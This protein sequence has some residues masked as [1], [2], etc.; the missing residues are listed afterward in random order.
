MSSQSDAGRGLGRLLR[1]PATVTTRLCQAGILILAAGQ[2]GLPHQPADL[3]AGAGAAR[4]DGGRQVPHP[5]AAAAH[6]QLL[7][8]PLLPGRLGARPLCIPGG[9]GPVGIRLAQ[10]LPPR[11]GDIGPGAHL[12]RPRHPRP[13]P[14][15]GGGGA[16]GEGH[17]PAAGR[18][19][20]ASLRRPAPACAPAAAAGRRRAGRAVA[21]RGA[22][23]AGARRGEPGGGRHPAL[24]AAHAA[25]QRR[26]LKEG[27]RCIDVPAMLHVHM[28]HRC[29]PH[30]SL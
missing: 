2:E 6:P 22:G 10:A 4:P 27:G 15:G 26:P 14:G 20:G 16:A 25:Q 11:A 21:P 9:A 5:Q 1:A 13:G 24:R 28:Q 3:R 7:L 30:T 29:V 19:R 8:C 18:G 23:A 17:L 12:P